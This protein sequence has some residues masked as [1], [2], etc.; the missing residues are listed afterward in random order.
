MKLAFC[1]FKYFPFGGLQR[2]FLKIAKACEARGHEI[3]VITMSMEDKLPNTFNIHLLACKGFQNH[4]HCEGFAKQLK[5]LLEK[6]NYDIVI[7][8]N[9]MPYLDLYYAADVCYQA[10]TKKMRHIF[11]RLLPRYQTLVSLEKSIFEPGAKTKILYL[12]EN[13]RQEYVD[14][15]QTEQERFHLLSPGIEK[16]HITKSCAEEIRLQMRSLYNIHH[17]EFLL[18]MIGSGFKTKGLDRALISI[19]SLPIQLRERCHFFIIGQDRAKQFIKLSH[20]LQINNQIKFLGGRHD[21]SNFL[22]AADL[23]LHPAYH[24]TAGIVLL[25]ALSCGLPILTVDICGYANHIS[26]ADAGIVLN[27]PFCQKTC[28]Q[29]LLNMLTS[30]YRDTWRKNALAYAKETDLYNLAHH[31]VNFIEQLGKK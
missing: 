31:A 17:D 21:V 23:L 30:S 19:A 13:Q 24:E 5:L 12:A 15:Y 20:Y 2:D 18:L 25:E 11:Y 7:G 3:H 26:Q 16:K 28:N 27:S 6:S 4:Q 9:K 14:Y 1:L 29:Q 10:R 8:F 22:I